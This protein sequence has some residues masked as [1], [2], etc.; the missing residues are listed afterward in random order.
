MRRP[1]SF[2][3]K[4]KGEKKRRKKRLNRE[5]NH[6]HPPST[7]RNVF[8]EKRR[9]HARFSRK[10]KRGTFLREGEKKRGARVRCL[11][12]ARPNFRGKEKTTVPARQWKGKKKKKRR[13]KIRQGSQKNELFGPEG[14]RKRKKGSMGKPH[15]CKKKRKKKRKQ[16]FKKGGNDVQK[17]TTD[18]VRGGEKKKKKRR[19]G[20]GT[21]LGEERE[22]GKGKR[23]ARTKKKG[24][25][26]PASK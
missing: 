14:Q 13:R 17:V 5:E 19:H 20:E 25:N 15:D 10:K 26:V 4:K 2:D 12:I 21:A 6:P 23:K 24:K 18:L 7:Q 8:K 9:C 22:G 11:R 16:C 3:R 1:R